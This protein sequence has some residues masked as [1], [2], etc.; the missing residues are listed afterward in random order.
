MKRMLAVVAVALVCACANYAEAVGVG[1]EVSDE[2][3]ASVMFPMEGLSLQ[4]MLDVDRVS[5]GSDDD[6]VNIGGALW[7]P[8][9][10]MGDATLHFFAQVVYQGVTDM[11]AGYIGGIGMAPLV[12][13]GENIGLGGKVGLFHEQEPA[14]EGDEGHTKFGIGGAVNLHWFF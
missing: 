8:T 7:I 1:V 10:E 13:I 2:I 12:M 14:P 6:Y 5:N 9:T 3:Y 11:D 4:L